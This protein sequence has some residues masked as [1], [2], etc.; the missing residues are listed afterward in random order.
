[1]SP[2]EG[3]PNIKE[4]LNILKIVL[5]NVLCAQSPGIRCLPRPS[6]FLKEEEDTTQRRYLKMETKKMSALMFTLCGYAKSA[7][8]N[9]VK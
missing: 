7:K 8:A 5:E 6:V 4:N 1:M 2:K 3:K 9:N